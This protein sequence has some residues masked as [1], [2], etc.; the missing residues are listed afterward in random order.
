MTTAPSLS[1]GPQRLHELF[2]AWVA[3]QPN[4]LALQDPFIALSY[5]QLH[6]AAQAALQQLKSLGVRNGDRVLVVAENCVA[7]GA[8]VLAISEL[9]AWSVIV[10]AR[11][12]VR[13]LDT[14]S[15]HSGARLIIYTCQVSEDANVHA[16]RRGAKKHEWSQLGSLFVEKCQ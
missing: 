10:N 6:Q 5:L 8:L 1:V 14:L 9:G 16:E 3:V 7:V 2:T 11:L 12:S 15:E 4:A 13:E